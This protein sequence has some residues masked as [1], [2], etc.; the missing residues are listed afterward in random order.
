LWHWC[1]Q[2]TS[3]S[4]EIISLLCSHP[5]EKFLYIMH[6]T[7]NCVIWQLSIIV[8][9]QHFLICWDVQKIGNVKSSW[10]FCASNRLSRLARRHSRFLFWHTG[11]LDAYCEIVCRYVHI[12]SAGRCGNCAFFVLFWF[13]PASMASKPQRTDGVGWLSN[14]WLFLK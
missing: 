12:S 6:S 7:I 2:I 8:C 5:W 4:L 9:F 1:H 3:L 11:S 13:Q 10:L 14:Q